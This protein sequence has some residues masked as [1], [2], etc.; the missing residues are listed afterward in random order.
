MAS[1]CPLPGHFKDW[2]GGPGISNL[3][4]AVGRQCSIGAAVPRCDPHTSSGGSITWEFVRN[5][6]SW[7]LSH[8]YLIRKKLWEQGPRV[9]GEF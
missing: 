5:E 4:A 9:S 2:F 6:E 1:G 3:C 7:I 8:I